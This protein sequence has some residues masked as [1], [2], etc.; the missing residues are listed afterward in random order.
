MHT[1]ALLSQAGSPPLPGPA[2]AS[3]RWD[4]PVHLRRLQQH[5]GPWGQQPQQQQQA[6][7]VILAVAS[8][9][10][11]AVAINATS[12]RVIEA[13][14]VNTT[15]C[16]AYAAGYDPHAAAAADLATPQQA[17]LRSGQLDQQPAQEKQQQ[18]QQ[19]LLPKQGAAVGATLHSSLRYERPPLNLSRCEASVTVVA[20]A[21]QTV[22]V[23]VRA[24]AGLR[25]GI[26]R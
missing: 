6:A 15:R 2:N 21:R 9:N 3:G 20:V 10:L 11:G 17:V 16:I 24:D 5:V 4:P 12:G 19:P 14:R 8:S 7:P 1:S 26:L 23:E 18:Q 13:W 25:M 22:V